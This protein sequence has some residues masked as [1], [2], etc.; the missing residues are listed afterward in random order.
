MMRTTRK[1][2]ALVAGLLVAAALTP[3]VFAT[4]DSAQV[5]VSF[6]VNPTVSAEVVE[7]GLFVRSNAP[8]RLTAEIADADGGTVTVSENGPATGSA[9][10][11]IEAEGLVGYSLV[12]D[13][14]R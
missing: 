1:T 7:G 14:A 13:S 10:A 2:G 9:G 12:L 8:W 4:A 6:S 11:L 3:P 5:T